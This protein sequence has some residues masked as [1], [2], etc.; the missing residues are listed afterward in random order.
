[1]KLL[2]DTHTFLWAMGYP[3]RLSAHAA[4]LFRAADSILYLSAAS[5]WEIAIKYSLKKLQLPQEPTSYVTSRLT[6]HHIVPL[7]VQHNHA[8]A[9]ATLPPHH[10]DPFDRL[11]IAQARVDGLSILSMDE[12]FGRYDVP[13]IW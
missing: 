5:S 6:R 4:S 10:R 12:Q 1:M 9:V 13:V 8:L 11:L 2:L 7:P 3:E